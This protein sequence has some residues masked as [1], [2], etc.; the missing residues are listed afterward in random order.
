[1]AEWVKNLPAK[2]EMQVRSLEE[3]METHSCILACR[4]PWTEEP[5]G[6]Q[7]MGLYRLVCSIVSALIKQQIGYYTAVKCTHLTI[8]SVGQ[9]VHSDFSV[10]LGGS[11]SATSH[12]MQSSQ[13]PLKRQ[14]RLLLFYRERNR[15]RGRGLCL[16]YPRSSSYRRSECAEYAHSLATLYHCLTR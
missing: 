6:L 7:S 14:T 8:Y 9:K 2:Q 4:I 11:D 1:M 5:A 12:L 15:D 16:P 13:P 10:T 3:G